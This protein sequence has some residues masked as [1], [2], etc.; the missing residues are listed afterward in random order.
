[1]KKELNFLASKRW[2]KV[3]REK[4]LFK[5]GHSSERAVVAERSNLSISDIDWH[6]SRGFETAW[7]FVFGLK[8]ERLRFAIFNTC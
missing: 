7:R 8:T 4:L 6:D 2:E 3:G 1:M 5:I